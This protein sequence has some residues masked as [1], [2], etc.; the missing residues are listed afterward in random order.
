MFKGFFFLIAIFSMMISYSQVKTQINQQ[1]EIQQQVNELKKEIKQL[2]DE[3][4]FVEKTDPSEA[5]SLKTQLA[6]LKNML[7]MI[8][9]I[10]KPATQPAKSPVNKAPVV[11]NNSSPVEPVVLKQPVVIPVAAQAK[12]KLLWYRGKKIND[13]TLITVKGMVVQYNKYNKKSNVVK[14]Q[15]PKKGDPFDRIVQELVKTEQRKEEMADKFDKMKNGFL[16]YPE[17]KNGLALYDDL[18]KRYSDVVK[19][20]IEL[21]QMPVTI[22]ETN[23]ASSVQSG[24]GPFVDFFS[25]DEKTEQ[26]INDIFQ[27]DIN[28]DFEQQLALAKKLYSEL[29]PVSDFP[30]PPKHELGMCGT[31]DID[32]IERQKKQ[33]SIWQIKFSGAESRILQI[34]LS[35]ERQRTFLGMVSDDEVSKFDEG[36]FN[37]LTKRMSEKCE[38]LYSKYGGDIRYAPIVTQVVLG[39]ERQRQLLGMETKDNISLSEM[40]EKLNSAYEKYFDEQIEVKN[41]DF[42]LNIA[43]HLGFLRQKA[44]LGVGDSQNNDFGKLMEKISNY[45]RFELSFETDFIVEERNDEGE[46]EFKATGAMATKDKVYGMF[47]PGMC[48]YKMIPY[49]AD[50]LNTKLTDISIP[51]SVKSGVKTLK[52]EDG[53]LNNYNYSGP[54]QYSLMF[55]DFKIDFCTNSKPDTAWFLTF[56]GDQA[57]ESM[58][59]NL[60]YR[61]NKNY[62]SDFLMFANFVFVDNELK[63]KEQ[64]FMDVSQDVFKTIGGFQ[65]MNT[66]GSK[67]DKL[68]MQYE[69]KQ[70]MDGH[71]I[72]IQGLLNDKKATIL[73]TANNKSTVL[74]DKFIDTKRKL[75]D[76]LELTRGQLHLKIVHIPMH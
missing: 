57:V 3:I 21:P 47:V 14:I 38:I 30:A 56:I 61:N 16:F 4:K 59:D 36:I 51:F 54:L 69:G 39:F 17:L 1:S 23:N 31:C 71:R 13:S 27:N 70:Q 11:K 15:P 60:M 76:G 68:K 49:N 52:D 55:P 26:Y 66:D 40:M 43:A 46:L 25:Y 65:N 42:V 63:D 74:T 12:D 32:I 44:L 67:L 22:K 58:T 19:N 34:V 72:G 73:F 9:N 28:I 50:F 48:S 53:K 18:Y 2:E 10:G 33:D 24:S 41:H 64:E 75:E 5:A 6:A 29:P 45:N 62:K 8:D 35:V 20:T 37:N 7:S